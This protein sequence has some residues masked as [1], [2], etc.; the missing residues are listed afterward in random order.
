LDDELDILTYHKRGFP[1]LALDVLAGQSGLTDRFKVADDGS[2]ARTTALIVQGKTVMSNETDL[3]MCLAGGGYG[4]FGVWLRDGGIRGLHPRY[5]G[6]HYPLE[7]RRVHF[8]PEVQRRNCQM[9]ET[10][11]ATGKARNA[12][13]FAP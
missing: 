12:S 9:I 10:T 3:K 5:T 2:D 8:D 6:P 7:N 4:T 13:G 1:A 11:H